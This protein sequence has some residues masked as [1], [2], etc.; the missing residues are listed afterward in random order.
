MTLTYAGEKYINAASKIIAILNELQHEI[1]DI[2]QSVV[3]SLKIG[4]GTN[5]SPILMPTLLAAVKQKYPGIQFDLT[6]DTRN[7][8]EKM[9]LS[10]ILDVLISGYIVNSQD[11]ES[12]PL[13]KEEVLLFAPYKSVSESITYKDK[14]RLFP[15][16]NLHDLHNAKFVIYKKGRQFRKIQDHI[17]EQ[18]KYKPDIILETDNWLTCVRLVESGMAHTLLPNVPKEGE[19]ALVDKFCLANAC[20]RH[21]YLCYRKNVYYSNVLD[22]FIEVTREF[23]SL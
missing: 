14:D 18:N 21:T 1:D 22:K 6:E 8:L 15:V 20:Y 11:I 16:V 9:L 19:G 13:A 3:G 23:Y 2:Q 17:F 4:C 7:T 5:Y 10:G 12:I